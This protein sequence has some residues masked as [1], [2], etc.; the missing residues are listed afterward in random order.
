MAAS[1]AFVFSHRFKWSIELTV[2]PN[3]QAFSNKEIPPQACLADFGFTMMVLGSGNLMSAHTMVEAGTF[4]FM[5]L[6]LLAPPK[7]KLGSSIPTREADIFTSGLI[8]LQVSRPNCR[9]YSSGPANVCRLSRGNRHSIG[10]Q[11]TTTRT[12]LSRMCDQE[13]LRMLRLSDSRL[14]YGILYRHVG[15]KIGRD[16]RSATRPWIQ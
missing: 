3:R 14:F 9:R 16:G 6:K 5:A 2:M 10:P 12:Q 4:S 7:F 8:M 11:P 1:K 13:N 15:V